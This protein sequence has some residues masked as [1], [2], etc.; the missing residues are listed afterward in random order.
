MM[1]KNQR[2]TGQQTRRCICIILI[3]FGLASCKQAECTSND[4]TCAALV[5]STAGLEDHGINQDA[6]NGLGES[7]AD[8][9]LNHIA[10]IESVDA[11]DYAKNIAYFAENGYDLII[12]TGTGMA[13]E[14]RHAA[15]LYPDSVFL[16]LEQPHEPGPA[17]LVPITFAEDQMGYLAGAL[18]THLTETRVVGAVCE[19][20]GIPSMWRYCEGFRA[21]VEAAADEAGVEIKVLVEY[22][23][24]GLQEKL[25]IDEA[26]GAER[27]QDLVQR[28]ADVIF[29][30][31][32]GTGQ[33][34]LRAASDAGI[35]SIG[36]E[37]NQAAALGES[38]LSLVTSIYGRAGHEIQSV[39]R[40][41]HDDDLD[42]RVPGLFGYV[43]L[44]E[45]LPQSLSVEMDELLSL[46]LNGYV[47]TN[48]TL[49][50]P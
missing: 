15:D 28:G 43:P 16:G 50:K 27:A 20:S 40:Q 3:L 4:V 34:A 23:D 48:I 22:R 9:A 39:I 29:A 14:T 45:K 8:G 47:Q 41:F 19:T 5:T 36:T 32:G 37:R 17:N 13:D 33:G 26:W 46:L 6:W 2:S 1:Q 24:D 42:V 10:Y 21:G 35:Y 49:E 30:A 25:F 12:T 44:D 38:R 7:K 31:G 18:A 11:R